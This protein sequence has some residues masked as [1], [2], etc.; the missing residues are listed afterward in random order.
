MQKT[1]AMPEGDKTNIEVSLPVWRELHGRKRRPSESFDDVLRRVTGMTE[2]EG[3]MEEPEDRRDETAKPDRSDVELP[4]G[5][6]QHIDR[7]DARVA[8]G[9]A[10]ELIDSEMMEFSAIAEEVSREHDL[11]YGASC[12]KRDG[13]WWDRIIKP[14]IKANG[15]SHHP[16]RGWGR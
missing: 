10:L 8:I 6:P 15:A 4:D 7:A 11:G 14:G 3:G 12:E 1:K 9:A 13:A 16:G 5:M 2:E